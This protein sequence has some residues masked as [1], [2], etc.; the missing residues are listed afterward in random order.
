LKAY[1]DVP[2]PE[3]DTMLH[4]DARLIIVAGS[5]TTAATLT[6]LFYH[7]A[8]EPAIVEQI[9]EELRP[10]TQGEWHDKDIHNCAT[11]NGAIN[12]ALRLHPPVPSGVQ[13][14][15][16]KEGMHIGETFIPGGTQY[17]MPQYVM[18]RGKPLPY[19]SNPQTTILHQHHQSN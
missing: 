13:R 5:D 3:Q 16:P 17:W 18:G 12:E 8:Q 1:K 6:Y 9:R 10:L 7:L 11:L 19:P 14:T 2:H 4:A 15:T